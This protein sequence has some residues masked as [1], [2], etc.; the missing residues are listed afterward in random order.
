MQDL[1][2]FL[3]DIINASE[4]PPAYLIV[5]ARFLAKW[6]II[7]VAAALVWAWIRGGYSTRI[8][9][10][11]VGLATVSALLVNYAIVE[12]NGNHPRPFVLGIGNQF[13]EH[14]PDSSFPSD[15][16]TVVLAVAI[17]LIIVRADAFW[18]AIALVTALGVA[19]SRVYL[20]IHWPLDIAGSVIVA[21]GTALIMAMAM[22]S[23]WAQRL[24]HWCLKLF[25]GILDMAR[26][27]RSLSPRSF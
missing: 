26:I 15:H 21:L 3:F 5:F 23:G 16:S 20:G 12:T 1:N 8:K 2:T 7:V 24:R 27:P 10:F 11:Y 18:S 17:S 9:L 4:N 6:M 19:W 25:D 22:R 13:L 14:A